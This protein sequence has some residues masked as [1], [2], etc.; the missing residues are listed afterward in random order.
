MVCYLFG[1]KEIHV[2]AVSEKWNIIK[3]RVGQFYLQ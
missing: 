2:N 3:F 1:V